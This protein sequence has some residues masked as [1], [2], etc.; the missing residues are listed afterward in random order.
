M[1]MVEP[2]GGIPPN[3]FSPRTG[4]NP[5]LDCSALIS[6]DGHC[7]VE[8]DG[9]GSLCEQECRGLGAVA[10]HEDSSS[11]T[12]ETVVENRAGEHNA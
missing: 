11:L 1:S 8:R 4:F 12:G 6:P 9:E 10:I 3:L 2:G 5:E 7:M